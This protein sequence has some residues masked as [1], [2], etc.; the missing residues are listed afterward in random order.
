MGY[1]R[2]HA[3]EREIARRNCNK[4]GCKANWKE[5]EMEMERA[6]KRILVKN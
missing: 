1:K 4:I 2:K 5:I 3:S 6:N